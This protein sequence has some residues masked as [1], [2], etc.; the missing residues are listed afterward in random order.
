VAY[1]ARVA[2]DAVVEAWLAL[3]RRICLDTGTLQ[4]MYDYGE[5]LWEGEPF[6]PLRRDRQVPG[7]SDE[8][9]ALRNIFL[10]N[11]RAH[12]EFAV[13]QASLREVA[14]RNKQ[15]YTQWVYD[16]LD[17]WLVSSEGEESIPTS[18]FDDPRFGNISVKD[19]R[20]LQDALDVGCDAFMTMERR[21]PTAAAFVEKATGLQ[22]LRPTAYWAL[23][24]PFASLYC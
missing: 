18:T 5:T 15:C 17:S 8:I 14:A 7:L 3:P 13:T 16:V 2:Q 20:L 10:V 23:L 21:L 9:D 6:E 1:G 24:Q 4:T 22:I 12:F 19:R 11:E